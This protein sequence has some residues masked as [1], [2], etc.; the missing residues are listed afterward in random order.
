M[1]FIHGELRVPPFIR[2]GLTDG[3]LVGLTRLFACCDNVSSGTTFGRHTISLTQGLD[4]AARR[5]CRGI[6]RWHGVHPT[7]RWP[8][9]EATWYERIRDSLCQDSRRER[10]L[11]PGPLGS[12]R[13]G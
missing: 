12:I 7:R 9:P 6:W 5:G 2:G 10:D 4:L 11:T 1:E 3:D 8:H 13:R